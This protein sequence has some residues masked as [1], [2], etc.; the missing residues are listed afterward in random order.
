[1]PRKSDTMDRLAD[2][3]ALGLS[4]RD[5]AERI[6]VSYDQANAVFQRMKRKLGWQAR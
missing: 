4:I 1:M 5:A 3:L 6:G 2:A